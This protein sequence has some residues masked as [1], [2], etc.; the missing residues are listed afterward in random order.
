M[1]ANLET[2]S[3]L[4][5]CFLTYLASVS[6]AVLGIDGNTFQNVLGSAE[7]KLSVKSFC[8]DDHIHV[9]QIR[10]IKYS[11]EDERFLLNTELESI[12]ST[13]NAP[14]TGTTSASEDASSGAG[15]TEM[16]SEPPL[17]PEVISLVVIKR[18]TPLS[19]SQLHQQLFITQ[20]GD[21]NPLKNLLTLIRHA[22]LP[23]QHHLIE[24]SLQRPLSQHQ[25]HNPSS[26]DQTSYCFNNNNNNNDNDNNHP[27][28]ISLLRKVET[29]LSELKIEL[30]RSQHS[31][32]IPHISLHLH[33]AI[34]SYLN[35]CTHDLL[36]PPKKIP[37]T[38]Y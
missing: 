2:T 8:K 20:Y 1:S 33:P 15:E 4:E 28:Q 31:Y 34:E 10:K 9:L 25:S 32:D 14:V 23:I 30:L 17:T 7:A 27:Q 12:V 22:F 37:N 3:G 11:N 18:N 35:Q 24:T 19:P 21:L 29:R 13:T 6:T 5:S 36:Y 38:F 16:A 26:Q